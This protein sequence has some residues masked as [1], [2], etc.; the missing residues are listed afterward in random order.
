[1]DEATQ[2]YPKQGLSLKEGDARVHRHHAAQA[3]HQHGVHLLHFSLQNKRL[4][5]A[6]K[7]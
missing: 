1:M 6:V 2:P 4:Q 5:A 3:R 7:E